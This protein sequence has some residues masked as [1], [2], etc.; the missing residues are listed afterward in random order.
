MKPAP[1][2]VF[3]LDRID[4]ISSFF[5]RS[6]A[7][8]RNNQKRNDNQRQREPPKITIFAGFRNRNKI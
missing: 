1:Q 7:K 5:S 4:K 8:Q 6:S 3:I 2:T